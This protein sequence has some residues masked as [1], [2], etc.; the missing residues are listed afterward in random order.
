MGMAKNGISGT[1][2]GTL[3]S[4]GLTEGPWAMSEAIVRQ[5]EE[6]G[7]SDSWISSE[8]EWRYF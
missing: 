7:E 3:E 8:Y 5:V 6:A 1:L 2:C 4:Q